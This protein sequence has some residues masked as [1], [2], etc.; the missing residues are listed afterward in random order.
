MHRP[1]IK[2]RSSGLALGVVCLV[3]GSYLVW[4][5]YEGRGVARPFVLRFLPGP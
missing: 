2:D 3:A 1:I 5:G 4:E